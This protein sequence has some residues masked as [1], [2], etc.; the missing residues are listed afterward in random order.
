[1]M[2]SVKNNLFIIRQIPY[3]DNTVICHVFSDD[4]EIIPVF[5]RLPKVR[6]SGILQPFQR[7]STQLKKS[8]G[9]MYKMYN[10]QSQDAFY[11]TGYPLIA[12]LYI[13]ELMD[14]FIYDAGT[15]E[16][17]FNLYYQTL[18]QLKSKPLPVVVRGFELGLLTLIGYGIDTSYPDEYFIHVEQ[19]RWLINCEN[20]PLQ[21]KDVKSIMCGEISEAR[22]QACG[23]LIRKMLQILIPGGSISSLDLIKHNIAN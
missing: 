16:G 9:N 21:V 11:L 4:D 7:F 18:Q 2:N 19:E 12:G 6:K 22:A 15:V 14:K 3:Q 17:S 8:T 5:Y 13:N 1:M 10:I 23:P 20:S